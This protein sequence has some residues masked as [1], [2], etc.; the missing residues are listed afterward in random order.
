MRA[1]DV[2]ADS[3]ARILEGPLKSPKVAFGA[4]DATN[5]PFAR[6]AAAWCMP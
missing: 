6:L 1:A 4:L 2:L 3:G 5:P